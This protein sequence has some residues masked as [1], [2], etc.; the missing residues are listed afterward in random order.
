MKTLLVIFL[1]VPA[2]PGSSQTHDDFSD[3]FVVG[4]EYFILRSGNAKLILQ[5]HKSGTQPAVTY[6]LFDAN[7]PCQTLTKGRAFNYVPGKACSASALEV[8]MRGVPFTALGHTSDVHW[9]YHDGIPSVEAHWW[10]GGISV[11]ESFA[12]LE[13]S[14]TFIRK[15]TLTGKDLAG[16]DTVRLRLSIPP[17]RFFSHQSMLVGIA[18]NVALG[19][20]FVGQASAVVNE[21]LGYIESPPIPITPSAEVA[22]TTLLTTR[23]PAA[24]YSYEEECGDDRPLPP[25]L[26]RPAGQASELMGLKAEYFNNPD[27]HGAPVVVRVDT[28]FCPSWGVGSPAE[29]VRADSFS[30]RWTGS[31]LPSR[32]GRH[33]FSLVADERARLYVGDTLLIDCWENSRNARPTADIVLESGKTY[34]MR[35]EFAELLGRARLRVRCFVPGPA[36]EESEVKAGVQQIFDAIAEMKASRMGRETEETRRYWDRTGSIA[37]QDSL[38]RDLFDHARFAL[39]GM[40]GSNGKM[41]ASIFEYGDQWVRDGSNVALGLIHAGHFESARALLS[42]ILADLVSFQG[43]M[44]ASGAFDNPDREEFDQ[45]GVLMHALKAY[46]D[47]TGDSLLISEHRAKILVLI[48]RPLQARFRD[49]TGMVHNR[50]EYWERTF[51]DGYELAYQTFMVRGLRDAADLSRH[52]GVPEKAALW[53]SEA[54]AFQHAMID[55]PSR[56][57]VDQGSLI[58]RRNIDG[59]IADF[60]PGQLSDPRRDDPAS[61]EAFHR[62]NPD[63]S[64][65]LPIVL[66]VVD[67]HS[68]L[69]R[70][71]L[72][73][74]EEIWN[75]RWESGGYERYH[76]SSQQDQPGP[77]SFATASIARAQHDAGLYD[78]S[79]RSLD[80]L[81]HVQ[82]G[83]AGAWFEE[84]PLIRSQLFGAGI[85]P[86]TSAE[87]ASFA[88]RHWLGLVFEG[89][90][91]V[92]RPALFPGEGGCKADLRLRS[93]RIRLEIEDAGEVS[94]AVINSQKIL[95]RRD[96]SILVPAEALSGGVDIKVYSR[97]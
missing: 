62:L 90:D 39:P 28:N 57:L 42:L 76:S 64:S 19:I 55:H 87:V 6:M 34:D 70:K 84:I 22:V 2:A 56:S 16:P 96:G 20:G 95:P 8:V 4:R 54:D 74:L 35:I 63:A 30:V 53:R 38:V 58:K 82:G 79:R 24:G 59:S 12:A 80:W 25:G 18:E 67:P 83:N 71:T 75:A 29:G 33:R 91:L 15:I 49:S 89:S 1:L 14:N 47:W 48:E 85:V 78:M 26:L 86:W 9:R 88:V 17:G 66:Q 7:K 94:H 3:S 92:V 46:R 81:L 97:R 44:I 93:S 13:G 11:T 21:R 68:A 72:D 52:L 69:A 43:T 10:A 32:N 27:L 73:R 51:E 50:R 45:M 31:L 77:W 41:D 40:V 60:I 37:T 65:A 36:P 23:I 5:S 61:T